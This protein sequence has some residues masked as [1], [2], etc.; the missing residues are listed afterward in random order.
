M[1]RQAVALA[2]FISAKLQKHGWRTYSKSNLSFVLCKDKA[3]LS[4]K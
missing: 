2:G 3:F 4:G 1:H